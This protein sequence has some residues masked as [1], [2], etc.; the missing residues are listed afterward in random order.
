MSCLFRVKSFEG[1]DQ[2]Y[3]ACEVIPVLSSSDKET[4]YAKSLY[5]KYPGLRVKTKEMI[6]SRTKRGV[7]NINMFYILGRDRRDKVNV[8]INL[9]IGK[10]KPSLS[11]LEEALTVFKDKSITLGQWKVRVPL[12]GYHDMPINKVV[13]LYLSVL[14]NYPGIIEFV[15]YESELTK[16]QRL[17]NK[18]S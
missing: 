5:S 18:K 12:I 10:N 3:F 15:C 1:L 11:K 14:S 8:I 6:D 7:C 17:I 16:I 4:Q 9:I 2:T 13:K